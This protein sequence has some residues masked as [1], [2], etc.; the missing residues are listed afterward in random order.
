MAK[1]AEQIEKMRSLNYTVIVPSGETLAIG[2]LSETYNYTSDK[3]VPVLS[4]IPI[5][6]G[7]FSNKSN[8]QRKRNL[9]AYI[10]PTNANNF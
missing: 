1:W 10:T 9:V 4:A 7:L 2:G 6:G 3:S 8:I 5:I